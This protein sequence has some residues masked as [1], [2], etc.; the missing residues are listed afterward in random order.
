MRIGTSILLLMSVTINLQHFFAEAVEQNANPNLNAFSANMKECLFKYWKYDNLPILSAT[1]ACG[2][3]RKGL[4]Y[5]LNSQQALF[6]SC[7][8]KE[9]LIP[10]FTAHIVQHTD[11]RNGEAEGRD[12]FR[13]ENGQNGK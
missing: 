3:D 5:G 12:N 6:V 13:N 8:N 4:C 10:D 7:Y 2:K 1:G 9:T 11:K